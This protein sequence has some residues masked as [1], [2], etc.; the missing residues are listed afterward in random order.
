MP[1]ASATLKIFTLP[2]CIACKENTHALDPWGPAI[3]FA[4]A[5][6]WQDADMR[7]LVCDEP[8]GRCAAYA[9]I[10]LPREALSGAPC[11]TGG[12]CAHCGAVNSREHI[13]DLVQQHALLSLGEI[14]GN[15]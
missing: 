2:E 12:V 9:A 7:C 8:I 5:S 11:R 1:F 4:M 14:Q 3:E 13:F 10:I 15:A 6:V